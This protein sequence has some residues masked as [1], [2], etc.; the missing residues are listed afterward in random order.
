MQDYKNFYRLEV[1]FFEE[2]YKPCNKLI[3][4]YYKTMNDLKS[5]LNH[6]IRIP[7]LGRMALEHPKMIEKVGP[8]HLDR[9]DRFDLRNIYIKYNEELDNGRY[10]PCLSKRRFI[11]QGYTLKVWKPNFNTSP[12]LLRTADNLASLPTASQIHDERLVKIIYREIIP[13]LYLVGNLFGDFKYS[14]ECAIEELIYYYLPHSQVRFPFEENEHFF[15]HMQ[16]IKAKQ[17][18]TGQYNFVKFDEIFNQFFNDY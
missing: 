14:D 10:S 5:Y 1:H 13:R 17:E 16:Y 3:T 6:I 15:P 7:S 8:P 12:I 18:I 9:G 11:G 2:T 4:I